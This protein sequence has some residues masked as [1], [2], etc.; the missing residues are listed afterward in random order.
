MSTDSA[1]QRLDFSGLYTPGS[2]AD[3]E[4][5]VGVVAGDPDGPEHSTE[6]DWLTEHLAEFDSGSAISRVPLKDRVLRLSQTRDLTPAEPLIGKLLYRNTLA[7][8]SAERGSYKSFCAVA[9]ACAIA[10]GK[11]WAQHQVPN[12]GRVVYVAAE[13][14]SG[15]GLRVRAWCS[16]Y[17]VNPEDLEDWLFILPEPF[18]LGDQV[19]DVT[20]AVELVREFDADLLVLDT[21][22]RCTVG[23]DENSATDQGVAIDS[24]E[25]IRRAADCTVLVVHHT[26]TNGNQ[27]GSTAWP[28]AVWSELSSTRTGHTDDN[29]GKPMGVT[30]TVDKHK[31]AEIPGPASFDLVRETVPEEWAPNLAEQDRLTLVAVPADEPHQLVNLRVASKVDTD[32]AD[33]VLLR[34]WASQGDPPKSRDDVM[35]RTK[36]SSG[37]GWGATRAGRALKAWKAE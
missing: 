12:R 20:E 31:D 6:D 25:R 3:T 4:L 34:L 14:V 24:A 37:K 35:A 22:H 5:K 2:A 36:D 17:G 15:I 27:R 11:D 7:Q 10:A 26:G 30:I 21:R 29:N 8:Y 16:R 13:D 9:V 1:V 18:Q 19:V 28:G 33:V 32:T 23:L